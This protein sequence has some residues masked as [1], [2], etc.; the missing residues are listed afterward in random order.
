MKKKSKKN[1]KSYFHFILLIIPFIFLL[2]SLFTIYD[3]GMNW[4]SPNHFSRGQAYLRYIITGKRN[5]EGLPSF[6]RNEIDLSS[7][8]D[9]KTGEICD[10]HKKV[11]VS[12]FESP[13]LDYSW[14][15]KDLYGHPPFTDLMISISNQ[16]FFRTLGWVEDIEAYHLFGILMTFILSMTVSYWAY[17]TYGL[18]AGI[19]SGLTVYL[20]PLLFSE[21]HFN[22]KDPAMAAFFGLGIFFFW[23]AI[24]KKSASYMLL[25]AIFG[26]FSFAT[27]INYV[28]APIILFPWLAFLIGSRFLRMKKTKTKTK[29]FLKQVYLKVPKRL[30]IVILLYPFINFAI[31][32]AFWPPLWDDPINGLGTVFGYYDDIGVGKCNYT[33]F[34]P[35]WFFK[36]SD[37]LTIKYLIYTF[38]P[39]VLFFFTL[40]FIGSIIK[41][42]SKNF[43]PVLLIS[44][45]LVTLLRVT[46]SISSIY[47]GLR[48]IMEIVV[49]IALI[50]SVGVYYSHQVV[51]LIFGKAGIKKKFINVFSLI[52]ILLPFIYPTYNL[53]KIHP[54]QNLYFNFF[55]GGLRG[56]AEKAFPGA[57]NTY[58]NGYKQ[59]V[60]WLNK[61]A[62]RNA[63]VALVSGTAQNIPRSTFR[64]DILFENYY[65][66][67]YNQKGEYLISLATQAE[68]FK[69]KFRYKYLFSFINPIYEL[70]V[71]N[72]PIVWIWK[73][74]SKF[75]K[76]GINIKNESEEESEFMLENDAI[77]IELQKKVD[78]K[79]LLLLASEKC[80][81]VLATSQPQISIDGVNYQTLEDPFEDFTIEEVGSTSGRAFLF[82]GQEAKYIKIS[83]EQMNKCADSE[84]SITVFIFNVL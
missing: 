43:L 23:L 54:N 74:D 63:K 58:G 84:L 27:K 70:K 7:R 24:V 21:Q 32:I 37:L 68:P 42:K 81:E 62:E 66:S 75:V 36:C 44:F 39:V 48:Q 2:V 56:A 34:S 30:L 76:E 13:L 25:S 16:I 15:E 59:A 41:F 83:S 28:F 53:Y 72:V 69:N 82:T 65:R 5:Y 12:E 50:T 6:C 31:F 61:N 3:Y 18:L 35:N 73:N 80:M 19:V 57:G 55:I 11:R 67:G 60:L 9:Y 71:D 8:V 79:R 45:F 33:K 78:L 17:R 47:G 77:N 4:D 49:P 51:Y 10:R 52:I 38:P 22:V 64:E 40:G 29:Q 46:L 1:K 14:A 20:Y 26:G